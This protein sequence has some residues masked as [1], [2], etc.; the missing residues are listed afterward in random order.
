MCVR[1]LLNLTVQ[2][3]ILFCRWFWFV[4]PLESTPRSRPGRWPVRVSGF[5]CPFPLANEI[6]GNSSQI[7]QVPGIPRVTMDIL[8]KFKEVI[9]HTP[10]LYSRSDIQWIPRKFIPE[11]GLCGGGPLFGLNVP[12]VAIQS[13][14]QGIRIRKLDLKNSLSLTWNSHY[15]LNIQSRLALANTALANFLWTPYR[16]HRNAACAT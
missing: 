5:L 2:T 9:Y 16:F 6:R 15:L 11:N 4:V 12:F 7:S 8:G 13:D 3:H 10:K 1:V 14:S